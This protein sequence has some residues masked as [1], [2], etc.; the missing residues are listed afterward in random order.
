MISSDLHTRRR[1][2]LEG[3]AKIAY[4]GPRTGAQ[5][6]LGVSVYNSIR[7][8]SLS[9]WWRG[10]HYAKNTERREMGIETDQ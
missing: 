1:D 2:T 10:S 8:G 9:G 7:L 5:L 6:L 4:W 3:Q